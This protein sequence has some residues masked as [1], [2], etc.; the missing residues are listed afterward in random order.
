[1]NDKS[2][3]LAARMEQSLGGGLFMQTAGSQ[4]FAPDWAALAGLNKKIALVMGELKIV[5]ED[6]KHQQGWKYAS[7]GAVVQGIRKS[8]SKHGVGLYANLIR[9]EQQ[10]QGK[11]IKSVVEVEFTFA[12]GETGALRTSRW[13]GEAMDFGI[14]DKGLNKAYTAAEKY[15]LMRTFLVSTSD[16]V[17]PD[18]TPQARQDEPHW[19]EKEQVRKRFWAWTTDMALSNKEVHEALGVE[20]VSDYEGSMQEAKERIIAYVNTNASEA[21]DANTD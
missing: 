11:G 5:Q 6:A 10:S 21:A 20:H 18:A 12:D 1:M 9:H 7:Y 19:I 4:T 13:A 16:D 3:V 15:F 17:E 2:E 8:L 14:A